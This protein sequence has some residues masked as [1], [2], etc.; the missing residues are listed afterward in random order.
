MNERMRENVKE[1]SKK[2]ILVTSIGVIVGVSFILGTK[3][4]KRITAKQLRNVHTFVET[5]PMFPPNMPLSK[6]KDIVKNIP[7]A[8]FLDAAVVTIGN[9]QRIITRS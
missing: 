1:K 3:V 7:D 9:T 5:T 2:V 8:T 4:Q 6:I